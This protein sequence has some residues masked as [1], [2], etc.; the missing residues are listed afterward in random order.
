[1][2]V[3]FLSL[4]CVCAFPILIRFH[5]FSFVVGLLTASDT[6]CSQAYGAKNMP[7]VGIVFQ[8][9]LVIMA[10]LCIPVL[11][12]WSAS[13]QLLL[14]MRQDPEIAAM[15]GRYTRI[16]FLGFPFLM[17]FEAVK[18]YLQAQSIT[19]PPMWIS[20][21]CGVLTLP[22]GLFY[23]FWLDFGFI[24]AAFSVATSWA[25]QGISLTLYTY[26]SKAYAPTWPETFDMQEILDIGGLREYLALGV[27]GML[28]GCAEW[29][30]FELYD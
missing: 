26:F 17:L 15:V 4:F 14:V 30:G 19:A 10:A 24:G 6:L 20:L 5:C 9:S 3:R 21:A 13:G 29:W 7:R 23:I 12:F 22:I 27:P 1:L 25:M 2:D 28:M 8:R 18:R 11:L 16:A